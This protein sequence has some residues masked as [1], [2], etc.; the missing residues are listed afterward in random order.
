M[1][2][3]CVTVLYSNT[4][5]L[6]ILMSEMWTLKQRRRTC[7]QTRRWT[8]TTGSLSSSVFRVPSEYGTPHFLETYIL[9]N[10]PLTTLRTGHLLCGDT[11][12]M[13]WWGVPWSEVSLYLKKSD[14]YQY[15]KLY[16]LNSL[17]F[18]VYIYPSSVNHC[19]RIYVHP[20][21]CLSYFV[22]AL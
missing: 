2:L 20:S 4:I 13:W 8:S 10:V 7:P 16:G 18:G 6:S 22:F 14:F 15:I 21:V 17:Y 1:M 3:I 12:V 19:I 5:Y 11:N 9:V